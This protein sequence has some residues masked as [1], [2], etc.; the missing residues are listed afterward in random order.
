MLTK[1]TYLNLLIV[2]AIVASLGV[3]GSN[4]GLIDSFT[5]SE[6]GEN[7]VNSS[8]PLDELKISVDKNESDNPEKTQETGLRITEE[9]VAG[10]RTI[11]R[12]FN[13][14]GPIEDKEIFV[15]NESVGTTDS[16]GEVGFEVPNTQEITV[17]ASGYSDITKT[18]EGYEEES[19]VTINTLSPSN[20]TT[21]NNY[22]DTFD[23][24]VET[25]NE[26]FDIELFIDG[27]SR[28]QEQVSEASKSYSKELIVGDSGQHTWEI[29]VDSNGE[30]YSTG[31]V[32]FETSEDIPEPSIEIINPSEGD[33]I[34]DY[35]VNFEV[36]LTTELNHT[37]AFYNDN[38]IILEKENPNGVSTTETVQ[39]A[40]NQ[41]SHTF[42]AIVELNEYDRSFSDSVTFETTEEKQIAEP[43]L[44]YPPG[45][46]KEESGIE[47]L[48]LQIDA[49]EDISYE[50]WLANKDTGSEMRVTTGTAQSGNQI[51]RT[52]DQNFN[53]ST[54]YEWWIEIESQ[55]SVATLNST[56]NSF[57]W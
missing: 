22:R 20:E 30:S 37:L 10:E 27:E 4:T 24:S 56:T 51:E 36:D 48:D 8:K 2:G 50:V 40:L 14:K 21:V 11:I 9:P 31:P 18:V 35:L 33:S 7:P 57:T 42:E 47:R 32:P 54:S 13:E 6:E 29:K 3:L 44:L 12:L 34:N 16:N 28:F 39:K 52:V 46:Q 49:Y 19:P 53:S 38:S 45:A 5:S 23:W 55:E 43:V 15:N 1:S 26:G 17:S 41:G 25:Q